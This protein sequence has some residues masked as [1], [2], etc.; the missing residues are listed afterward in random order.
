MKIKPQLGHALLGLVDFSTSGR[1]LRRTDFHVGDWLLVTTVNSEYLIRPV[2][3]DQYRV[4]GGWFDQKQLSPFKTTINGCTWGGS[5]IKLDV[6]A[7]CGLR[8]EFGNGVV[9]STIRRFCV[10]RCWGGN[11]HN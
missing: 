11:I 2:G 1:E 10:Y 5:V 6:V 8:L 9:T 3:E 4:S 7:V